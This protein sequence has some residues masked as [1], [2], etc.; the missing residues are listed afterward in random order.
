[1][2]ALTLYQPWASAVAL[3]LKRVETR[4]AW[5][6]QLRALIGGDLAIH[7][8]ACSH[9]PSRYDLAAMHLAHTVPAE[10]MAS[11]SSVGIEYPYQWTLTAAPRGAI[12]AVVRVAAVMPIADDACRVHP[13]A[14]D[15]VAVDSDGYVRIWEGSPLAMP[16]LADA[17]K[18][19]WTGTA[20]PITTEHEAFWGDYTPGRVAVI[21]TALRPL[22]EPV[23]VRGHQRAWNLPADVEAAV[24][25]QVDVA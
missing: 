5:A 16:A 21:T 2:K 8:G 3:G 20:D 25:S 6:M 7:A 9:W 24:R 23:P 13:D 17:G 18:V 15:Y 14:P 4:P 11:L 1:M 19:W 10:A 22:A 12:I